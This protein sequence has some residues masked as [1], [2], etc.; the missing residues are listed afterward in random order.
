MAE[1]LRSLESQIIIQSNAVT[2]AQQSLSAAE[3]LLPSPAPLHPT[4]PPPS[5]YPLSS[6]Q[7]S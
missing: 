2:Q 3:H 5:P 7:V 6:A 4:L 1:H